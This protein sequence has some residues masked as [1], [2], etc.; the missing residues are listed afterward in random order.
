LRSSRRRPCC[1]HAL[2]TLSRL[3]AG[4]EQAT[5]R[6][7]KLHGCGWMAVLRCRPCTRRAILRRRKSGRVA[8]TLAAVQSY[9]GAE[10]R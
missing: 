5:D 9:F 6:H 7:V 8:E 1:R 3:R 10:L 2:C 4:D